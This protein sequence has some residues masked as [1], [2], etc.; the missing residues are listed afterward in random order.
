VHLVEGRAR[1]GGLVHR[2]SLRLT[3]LALERERK[4]RGTEKPD[5]VP[6]CCFGVPLSSNREP[7]S[8][9]ARD[10]LIR[11][12]RS[13]HRSSENVQRV[14]PQVCAPPSVSSNGCP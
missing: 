14:L 10:R 1:A 4:Q 3:D 5:A 7:T 9:R 12:I 2:H 13:S 11:S 6:R 8:R